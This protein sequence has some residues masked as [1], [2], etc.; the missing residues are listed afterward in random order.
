MSIAYDLDGDPVDTFTK[1]GAAYIAAQ[2]V[3]FWLDRGKAVKVDIVPEE[4]RISHARTIYC[5]RSN[6]KI[7]RA[8][9]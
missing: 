3:G 9:V 1:Q 7:G 5:V 8:H 6:L 4:F 2:I